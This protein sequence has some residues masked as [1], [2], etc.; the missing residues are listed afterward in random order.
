MREDR[1]DERDWRDWQW[2]KGSVCA[3]GCF[4]LEAQALEVEVEHRSIICSL[5]VHVPFISCFNTVSQIVCVSLRAFAFFRRGIYQ[6]S[7]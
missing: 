5:D 1:E 6:Y 7:I 2:T 3:H 4:N